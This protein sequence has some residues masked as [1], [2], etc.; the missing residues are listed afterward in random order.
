LG[1]ID[2][3]MLFKSALS[4]QD[5]QKVFQSNLTSNLVQYSDLKNLKIFP[6]PACNGAIFIVAQ[7]NIKSIKLI[8]STG[9]NTEVNTQINTFNV[10]VNTSNLPKGIYSIVIESEKETFV[11]RI[12]I[13]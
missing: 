4:P 11:R 10:E 2:E 8:N 3:V 1:K 5:V 9:I 12:T 7:N 13:Y 6:N